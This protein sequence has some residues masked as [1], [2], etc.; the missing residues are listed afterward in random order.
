MSRSILIALLI[1]G[2][3]SACDKKKPP[4]AKLSEIP[5]YE[6]MAESL[7]LTP[8]AGWTIKKFDGKAFLVGPIVDGFGANIGLAMEPYSGTLE[9]YVGLSQKAL[10]DMKSGYKHTEKGSFKTDDG[11]EGIR[12]AHEITINGKQLQQTC[13][14]FEASDGNMRVFTA[15]VPA[16]RGAEFAPT[17]D[18]IMRTYKP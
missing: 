17:F 16:G 4:P 1:C 18:Q 11:I 10:I 8:P 15:S 6:M 12:I 7:P 5:G 13:Y 3:F 2:M 14:V 9:Q